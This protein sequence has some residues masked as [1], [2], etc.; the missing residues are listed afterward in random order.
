[1]KI[2][3]YLWLLSG[4]ILIF[5]S[6]GKWMIPI[7]IWIT[8]ICLLRFV[9]FSKP[10]TGFISVLTI[11]FLSNIFIWK[12]F[13]P[14]PSPLY[15]IV[16]FIGGVFFS[17]PF[18]IERLLIVRVKSYIQTIIFPS[19]FTLFSYLYTLI[20]PSGTFGSIAYS[21]SNIVLIQIVSVAGIWG[22]IF[23]LG[24]TASTVNYL[25]DNYRNRQ[26]AYFSA[27]VYAFI[28]GLIVIYGFR[29]NIRF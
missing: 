5:T 4:S 18:L 12:G 29:S 11:S 19:L 28:T 17:I 2:S 21:Q 6:N 1:M 20:S 22:I 15:Y 7:S 10:W 3:K 16:S 26:K 27:G 14:L 9:R 25:L 24:W 8:L 23:V 13:I